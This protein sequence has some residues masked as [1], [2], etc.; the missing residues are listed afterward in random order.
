[1]TKIPKQDT[2]RLA[3]SRITHVIYLKHTLGLVSA[4]QSTLDPA[5]S[6]L[7]SA[8]AASLNDPRF[9]IILQKIDE[10]LDPEVAAK[11]QHS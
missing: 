4:L 8:F 11:V 5:E 1:M 6:E 10:V 7:L 9:D 3:E 2:P